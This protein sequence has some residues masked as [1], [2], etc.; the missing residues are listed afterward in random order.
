MFESISMN[1][2]STVTGGFDEK[3]LRSWAKEHAP[4]T[5]STLKNKPMSKITR[6]D[7][8]RCVAEAKVGFFMRGLINSQLDR[9]FAER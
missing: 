7:A 1:E 2:L 3:E 5:Y 9:Y 4:K 8:D 6:A